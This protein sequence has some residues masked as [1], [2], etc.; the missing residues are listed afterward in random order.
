MFWEKE[1]MKMSIHSPDS[2]E[3]Q[4]RIAA[5]MAVARDGRRTRQVREAALRELQELKAQKQQRQQRR[6]GQQAE[7]TVTVVSRSVPA[8]PYVS[9][10]V[11]R[12]VPPVSIVDGTKP[13][14]ADSKDI[15]P[16]SDN[17]DERARL[18]E[19]LERARSIGDGERIQYAEERLAELDQPATPARKTPEAKP[20]EKSDWQRN[21]EYWYGEPIDPAPQ[22]V[23]VDF[24]GFGIP[25]QGAPDRFW[26]KQ[27]P[28]EA[29]GHIRTA[30]RLKPAGRRVVHWNPG[31]GFD[32]L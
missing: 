16:V 1:T 25:E 17:Q 2:P 30:Q 19:Y 24:A 10:S 15:A 22:Q 21:H 9:R 29:E 27:F 31:L 13:V 14:D 12:S 11:P 5:L 32:D 6:Q 4:Q 23:T 26:D 28:R 20:A 18:L 7:L 3:V 8:Q